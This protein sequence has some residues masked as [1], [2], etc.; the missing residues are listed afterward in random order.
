VAPAER[1][2]DRRSEAPKE[3]RAE[4]PPVIKLPTAGRSSSFAEFLASTRSPFVLAS[5]AAGLIAA[6]F[7]YREYTMPQ[8]AV[9]M[10]KQPLIVVTNPASDAARPPPAAAKPESSPTKEQR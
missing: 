1:L 4:L 9:L 3:A 6:A 5:V 8:P 10:A 2:P 7:V